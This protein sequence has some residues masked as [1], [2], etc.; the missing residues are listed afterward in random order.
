VHIRDDGQGFSSD[1]PHKSGSF[2]LSGMH[3]RA[4][5]AGG[6]VT[7]QSAPGEGTTIMARFPLAPD[8]RMDPALH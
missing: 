2:G 5:L 4:A 1:M 3:E 6:I 8:D 7:V